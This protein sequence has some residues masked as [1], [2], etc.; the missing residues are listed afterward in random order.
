LALPG[1][2][3]FAFR[4]QKVA[5][6]VD[7][8]FW[9][10][11][12]RHGR[13]PESNQEYWLPKLARNGRRDRRVS[14]ILRRM[15]WKVIRLWEHDL[16][17]DSLVVRRIRRMLAKSLAPTLGTPVLRRSHRSAKRVPAKYALPFHSDP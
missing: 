6:F 15:G 17:N 11:C 7:G 10:S 12:P 4:S 16:A 14:R 1:R 3:D 8:C 9:H 2:P 5:V 13:A